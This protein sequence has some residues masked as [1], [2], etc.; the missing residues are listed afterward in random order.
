[1]TPTEQMIEF[2]L[3]G[4]VFVG[5]FALLVGLGILISYVLYAYETY[6]MKR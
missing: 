3:W 2:V 1:V 5:G 6:Q 4:L